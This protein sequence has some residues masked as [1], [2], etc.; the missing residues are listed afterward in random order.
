MNQNEQMSGRV[1]REAIRLILSSPGS[2]CTRASSS[3]YSS[4]TRPGPA[5]FPPHSHS[6]NVSSLST[7]PPQIDDDALNV[8]SEVGSKTTLRYAVQLLT[9]SAITARI[10]GR[11][12][13]V[14]EDIKV[15]LFAHVF[16][17]LLY[18]TKSGLW[19][20]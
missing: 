13:I 1:T 5:L 3:V 11:Q 17:N 7:L 8:L 10:A 4:D 2:K 9:P 15:R 19:F 20:Q 6:L 14:R 18:P 16:E 12:N